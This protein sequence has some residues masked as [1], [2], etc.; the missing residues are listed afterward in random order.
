MVRCGRNFHAIS[1]T[2][3]DTCSVEVV[4]HRCK[5]WNCDLCRRSKSAKVIRAVRERFTTD[6]LWFLTIT[7][8]HKGTLADAWSDLGKNWN[9]LI[10][11]ARKHNEYFD[12]IKIVEPHKNVPFP[13]LHIL[14][15]KPIFTTDFFLY[16]K[17]LGFGQQQQQQR[18]TSDAAAG[19]ITKYLSKPWPDNGAEKCRQLARTRV[20]STSRSFGALFYK[21]PTHLVLGKFLSPAE[22]VAQFENASRAAAYNGQVLATYLIT[23]SHIKADYGVSNNKEFLDHIDKIRSRE[24]PPFGQVLIYS[25][26]IVNQCNLTFSGGNAYASNIVN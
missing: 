11:Y 14:T 12:Y 10:T 2:S 21:K 8:D 25:A 1:R 17:T 19:Y 24:I 5:S 23:E 22:A 7:L 18:I 15:S 4:P 3:V 20:L 9:L 6:N 13:H 16:S 26:V